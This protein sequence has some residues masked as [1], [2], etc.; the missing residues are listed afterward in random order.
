MTTVDSS[1]VVSVVQ[2][3]VDLVLVPNQNPQ[4]VANGE[5]NFIQ[6]RER[7]RT[8][9][10]ILEPLKQDTEAQMKLIADRVTNVEATVAPLFEKTDKELKRL[11]DVGKDVEN[12]LKNLAEYSQKLGSDNES[13]INN[14]VS[15]VA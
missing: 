13:R 7:V 15:N 8:I 1:N 6:L 3:L 12:K 11:E 10:E 4:M 14:L 5:L 2:G 9:S